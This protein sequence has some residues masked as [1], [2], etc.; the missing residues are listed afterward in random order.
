[1]GKDVADGA[2]RII[3]SELGRELRRPFQAQTCT[4]S[5]LLLQPPRAF[6]RVHAEIQIICLFYRLQK[7]SGGVDNEFT[8]KIYG[9]PC[10]ISHVPSVPA[11]PGGCNVRMDRVPFGWTE[12]SAYLGLRR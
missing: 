5:L 8:E 7:G 1:M 3:H 4:L 10:V 2:I 11:R 6:P 9:L 12:L